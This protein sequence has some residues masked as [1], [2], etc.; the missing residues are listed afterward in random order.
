MNRGGIVGAV[1]DIGS[2]A[3]CS[4]EKTANCAR[5]IHIGWRSAAAE[6][7]T[8]REPLPDPFWSAIG[9]LTSGLKVNVQTNFKNSVDT[10]S[11]EHSM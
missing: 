9:K 11:V 2:S 7:G 4:S 8:G 10:H 1:K 6:T 3:Q 5:E